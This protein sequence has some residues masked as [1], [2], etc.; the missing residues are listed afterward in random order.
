[1]KFYFWK[2]N[3]FFIK[4]MLSAEKADAATQFESQ[5]TILT[6]T[7]LKADLSQDGFVN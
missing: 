7:I 3:F 2:P 4:I 1:M 6:F 5:Y